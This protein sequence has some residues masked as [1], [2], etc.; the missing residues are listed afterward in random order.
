MKKTFLFTLIVLVCS[1]AALAQRAPAR[2]AA[3]K[4]V[5]FAVLNDGKMI[6]PI[7]YVNK[8]K[9]EAPAG[10]DAERSLLAAFHRNYYKAGASY[11]L[12]FG[13][14]NGGTVKVRKA[15]INADCSKNMA[16]VA[17]TATGTPLKGFVMAL[18]T[19]APGKSPA[20]SYRRRPTAEERS[21]IEELVKAEF[22]A[23][24]LTPG[25]LRYHN[26][27]AL[28]VDRD[29]KAEMVGSYWVEVDKF[30]R[31]LLFFIA[32]KGTNGKYSFGHKEYQSI[33]QSK[34]MSGEISHLDEGV[35]HELLLDVFDYNGDGVAEVFTYT[36]S[37]EGAGFNAYAR[38]GGK[39]T[40]VFD[41]SNYHCAF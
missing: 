23:Q 11:R 21:E 36:R 37:F 41:G 20:T 17:T 22:T 3:A 40:Q 34:V 10:G 16:D 15:D 28:D 6:E 33:D 26:L 39:W 31:G 2:A 13:G 12:I 30:T 18:A 9:L 8:G 29:G 4:P 32:G 14:A 38:S 19:N 35:Y 5:I 27:T 25:T 7:A 24:K 1:T